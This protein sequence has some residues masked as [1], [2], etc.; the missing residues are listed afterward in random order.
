MISRM[1]IVAKNY[2]S[3]LHAAQP[4][5]PAQLIIRMRVMLVPLDPANQ[6]LDLEGPSFSSA[7]ARDNRGVTKGVVRDYDERLFR[8]QTWVES[9]YNAFCI[10]FKKM[11][12]LSWN[13]QLILLP[14]DGTGYIGEMSDANYRDFIGSPHVPAHVQCC[15]DIQVISM[16]SNSRQRGKEPHVFMQVVRLDN[17]A[18]G[19]FRSS[20]WRI[21]NEDVEFRR[22]PF[23]QVAAA[24][25]IGHWMGSPV[26]LT[27]RRRY[28]DHVDQEAC[29]LMSNYQPGDDCSYG[30]TAGRKRAMMGMGQ[31]VTPYEA[32]SWLSRVRLHTNALVGWDAVHRV[33]F[34]NGRFPV[35]DRQERLVASGS[36]GARTSP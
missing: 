27:D 36:V 34:N 1:T 30:R 25:E 18:N 6:K 35:S 33:H 3:V 14:P 31:L 15:L 17:P 19:E 26:P 5:K 29:Q 28:M 21:T 13:N 9:E 24:H 4:A 23:L 11:V 10:K 12:E 8:C 7:L 22:A 32:E 16:M 2:D 20:A